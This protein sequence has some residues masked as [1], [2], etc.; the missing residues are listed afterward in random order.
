MALADIIN[1]IEGDAEREAHRVVRDAE[2]LSARRASE[3]LER[4][5]AQAERTRERIRRETEVEAATR[6]AAA[7][8]AAR[9]EA[10]R[11]RRALVEE[12]LAAVVTSL[13]ALPDEEFAR[14]LAAAIAREAR[15][16][17][18]VSLAPADQSLRETIRGIV[19][20]SAPGLELEWSEKPAPLERG[21]LV[22]GGRTRAEITARALV[23]ACRGDLEV[24]VASSLFGSGRA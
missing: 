8:L 15:S 11:E 12:A 16:G 17:D 9:D 21:A 13:E 4:A 6:V 3:T 20:K 19:E 22:T 24:T 14:F 1:R 2:E 23:D 7:R 5:R 18:V 10:L